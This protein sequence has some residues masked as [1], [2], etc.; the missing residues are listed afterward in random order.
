VHAHKRGSSSPARPITVT[1]THL[2]PLWDCAR[3]A[4]TMYEP[5][6]TTS[7]AENPR[8]TFSVWYAW[9]VLSLGNPCS[10]QKAVGVTARHEGRGGGRAHAHRHA[11][12]QA[13]ASVA[14]VDTLPHAREVGEGA[15]SG[16]VPLLPHPP[17][18]YR[19]CSTRGQ[20]HSPGGRTVPEGCGGGPTPSTYCPGSLAVNR[21]PRPCGRQHGQ[22]NHRIRLHKPR[23][24][25]HR[26]NNHPSRQCCCR[27]GW[28][29]APE[30]TCGN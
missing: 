16:P 29:R 17:L 21:G 18:N 27:R 9:Q 5:D 15:A 22:P 13:Q 3:K 10:S 11:R 4:S 8:D 19:Q 7:M 1:A 25:S 6:S 24:T 26:T 14:F 20:G 12:T 28:R 23:A 30:N 2:A